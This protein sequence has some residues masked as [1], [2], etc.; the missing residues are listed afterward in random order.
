MSAVQICDVGWRELK[1]MAKGEWY[2]KSNSSL[3]SLNWDRWKVLSDFLLASGSYFLLFSVNEQLML[4]ISLIF[5]LGK[6]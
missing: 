2:L 5:V 3:V 1:L 4:W 6:A